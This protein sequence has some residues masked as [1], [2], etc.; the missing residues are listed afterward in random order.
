[1]QGRLFGLMV[2]LGTGCYSNW[3]P[4]DADG[5]GVAGVTDCW[6]SSEDPI[7]PEGSMVY[8][9]PIQAADIYVGAEDRPYDGIDQNCDGSDDFDADGD[10]FVPN[11]YVGIATLGLA[12]TGVLP[13]G[14]CD[15]ADAVRHPDTEELCDGLINGCDA[16]LPAVEMDGDGDGFGDSNQMIMGCNPD[17]GYVPLDGDCDDLDANN[18]QH[19]CGTAIETKTILGILKQPKFLVRNPMVTYWT[20][21]TVTTLIQPFFLKQPKFVMVRSMLVAQI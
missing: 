14:D 21:Q 8:D 9:T 7:Q 1:M 16:S 6:E 19:R 3:E 12:E 5:D 11:E 13:G 20:Q 18:F 10:G 15:D 2:V 4:K 17:P